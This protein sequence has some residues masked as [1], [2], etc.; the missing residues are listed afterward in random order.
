MD[1][2]SAVSTSLHFCSCLSSLVKLTS[3]MDQEKPP[4]LTPRYTTC[5]FSRFTK[6][7]NQSVRFLCYNLMCFISLTLKSLPMQVLHVCTCVTFRLEMFAAFFLVCVCV[8]VCVCV[9]VCVREILTLLN[10]FLV[11]LS[12]FW[13]V[14][15][16]S[17][18]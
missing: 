10:L 5:L 14:D 18:W 6:H 16:H 2:S 4:S 1:K 11:L 3:N 8:C 13:S 9:F 17:F 12:C 7:L 15:A